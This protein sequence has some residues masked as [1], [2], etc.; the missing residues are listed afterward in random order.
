MRTIHL[1][2]S[3]DR[4]FEVG[5]HVTLYSALDTL[6]TH[7]RAVI[8]LVL[9][10]YG[11]REMAFLKRTLERFDDRYELVLHDLN[12]LDLGR[13][14]SLHGNMMPYTTL[15]FPEIIDAP[16]VLYIDSDLL[17]ATDLSIL[18][19]FEL[20]AGSVAAVPVHTVRYAV[21]GE[22]EFLMSLGIPEE[23]SYYNSGVVLFD[24][25]YWKKSGLTRRCFEFAER[26]AEHLSTADQ[27]VINGVLQSELVPLPEKYNRHRTAVSTLAINQDDSIYH[28]VGSPKPWDF[29]GEWLHRSYPAFRGCLV[30]TH[31]G[32]YKTYLD[33]SPLRLKRLSKLMPSYARVFKARFAQAPG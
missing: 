17:V 22:R 6:S 27:A 18:Y 5:L 9:K 21:P 29:L 19:E 11:S 33:F 16:R 30:N 26:Y 2:T 23:A 14:K 32:G 12:R 28:F 8:H 4:N 13:G 25:E 24:A 10:D 15:L 20:G 3:A 31:Y 7:S 1:A